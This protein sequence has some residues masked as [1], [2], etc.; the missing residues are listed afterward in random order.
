MKI[1][2]PEHGAHFGDEIAPIM[3]CEI[4]W[5]RWNLQDLPV[6]SKRDFLDWLIQIPADKIF[7]ETGWGIG[8]SYFGE[9][10]GAEKALANDPA[11]QDM[12]EEQR[13]ELQRTEMKNQYDHKFQYKT[14]PERK[15]WW[16]RKK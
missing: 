16:K 12:S 1:P 14:E 5:K 4:L 7:M 13:R 3:D 10:I 2:C 8:M 11:Y 6:L 9:Y 15:P